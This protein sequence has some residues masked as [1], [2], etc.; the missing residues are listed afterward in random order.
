M[1]RHYTKVVG[2]TYAHLVGEQNHMRDAWA[3]KQF[4]FPQVA[5][6]SSRN[7]FRH[8]LNRGSDVLDSLSEIQA[9]VRLYG[10]IAASLRLYSSFRGI[11]EFRAIIP[12]VHKRTHHS[13][14]I[15]NL[16]RCHYVDFP[17][18]RFCPQRPPLILKPAVTCK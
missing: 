6:L 14:L 16:L 11:A 4:K 1:C 15:T 7:G 18:S 10:S 5:A 12:H 2:I 13:F 8:L 9:P 3:L 17:R